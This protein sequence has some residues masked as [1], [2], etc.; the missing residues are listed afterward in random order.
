[1]KKIIVLSLILAMIF[2]FAGCKNEDTAG[3][4]DDAPDSIAYRVDV[5]E[6]DPNIYPDDYP[7]INID[8]FEKAF[9]SFKEANTKGELATYQ[10]I[11]NIFSVD[12]AYYE[13]CDNDYNG[14]MYK[15]YGWYADNGVS[16]LITF[17]AEGDQL[18]YYAYTTNG[19][20]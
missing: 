6:L 1:M 2:A 7:L 17:K 3:K 12:G 11:V 14:T 18:E 20:I 10:D 9:E 8:D 5:A 19:I 13:N 16:I 4:A 15:Y